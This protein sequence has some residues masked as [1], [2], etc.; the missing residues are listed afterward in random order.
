MTSFDHAAA[1][2]GSCVA[3]GV[4]DDTWT[5][6][7][8]AAAT[9]TAGVA[10]EEDRKGEDRK[11]GALE[12]AFVASERSVRLYE[13]HVAREFATPAETREAYRAVCDV[14]SRAANADATRARYE[15]Y[16]LVEQDKLFVFGQKEPAPWSAADALDACG[17]P[18]TARERRIQEFMSS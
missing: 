2:R 4:G 3:G 7:A 10:L 8:A 5:K 6:R 18:G 13:R 12:E 11:G 17:G 16:D 15:Y 14:A 9:T 1:W